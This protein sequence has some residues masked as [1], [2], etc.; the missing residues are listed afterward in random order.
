MFKK[1]PEMETK[2]LLFYLLVVLMGGCVPVLSLHPLYTKENV[3]F[4]QELL[5]TWADPNSPGTTWQF[6][7][8]DKDQNVYKLVFSD[9]DGRKGL[10]DTHLVKLKGRFF[11]DLYPAEFPCDLEDPNK[12]DWPY[13]SFFLV[14]VHTF[15]KVDSI[16]PTL[17]MRLTLDDKM[18]QLLK[19]NPK[20]VK[21]AVLEDKSVLTASTKELQAFVLKYADD[22]KLFGE[23]TVLK[24]IKAKDPQKPGDKQSGDSAGK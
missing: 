22:E 23:P 7:R 2:K 3:V 18:E 14:P 24:R 10:F 17:K 5:G 20:A 13:N 21:H 8:A 9:E 19:E 16:E 1:G 15:I 11:L 12:V 4:K 6:K